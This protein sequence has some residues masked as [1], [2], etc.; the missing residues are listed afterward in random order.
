MK[1][2]VV[3]LLFILATSLTAFDKE[4][5]LDNGHFST[6]SCEKLYIARKDKMLNP[7]AI[8]IAENG[9]AFF[10]EKSKGLALIS[11]TE[12]GVEITLSTDGIE[13]VKSIIVLG[14]DEYGNPFIGLADSKG[15][16]HHIRR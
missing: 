15:N 2:Y 14:F 13:E 16:Q 11:N 3:T 12:N 10:D 7:I 9:I 6:L 4:V 1:W 8:S 5:K